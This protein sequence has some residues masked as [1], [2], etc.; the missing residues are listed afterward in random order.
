MNQSTNNNDN[1]KTQ[2]E[3]ETQNTTST[4]INQT[5]LSKL[6]QQ[7]PND[8]KDKFNEKLINA[9]F[10]ELPNKSIEEFTTWLG[11]SSE[12]LKTNKNVIK[13]DLTTMTNS[14]AKAIGNVESLNTTTTTN[15]HIV[16]RA[17][18]TSTLS[19]SNDTNTTINPDIG[20][21]I[22]KKEID[23]LLQKRLTDSIGKQ[24]PVNGKTLDLRSWLNTN[25]LPVLKNG[26]IAHTHRILETACEMSYLGNFARTVPGSSSTH[27]QYRN[28]MFVNLEPRSLEL[29]S[30]RKLISTQYSISGTPT[31][32]N[33]VSKAMSSDDAARDFYAMLLGA[34]TFVAPNVDVANQTGSILNNRPEFYYLVGFSW[35][36]ANIQLSNTTYFD[37]SYINNQLTQC[38]GHTFIPP[39]YITNAGTSN[40][41]QVYRNTYDGLSSSRVDTN[42]RIIS[43]YFANQ[44]DRDIAIQVINK[45]YSAGD[46]YTFLNSLPITGTYTFVLDDDTSAVAS[47]I[48]DTHN[49]NTRGSLLYSLIL[50]GGLADLVTDYCVM[51]N[52]ADIV[53]AIDLI[54]KLKSN[55]ISKNGNNTFATLTINRSS[56]AINQWR[57]D[58]SSMWS[59]IALLVGQAVYTYDD[60]YYLGD[61]S[62]INNKIFNYS[63]YRAGLYARNIVKT[64][65]SFRNRNNMATPRLKDQEQFSMNILRRKHDDI[66]EYIPLFVYDTS[67]P[68]TK[69]EG[70]LS[71]TANSDFIIADY[72]TMA[73]WWR[74]D[75][76]GGMDQE[77]P[78]QRLTMNTTDQDYSEADDEIFINTVTNGAATTVGSLTYRWTPN[79]MFTPGS[80]KSVSYSPNTAI[81]FK[82]P[83]ILKKKNRC[84]AVLLHGLDLITTVSPVWYAPYSYKYDMIDKGNFDQEL[85]D[86]LFE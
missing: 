68:T 57:L 21:E 30:V 5:N 82:I 50:T 73:R 69:T 84:K 85:I 35:P 55:W 14:S 46:V 37:A 13:Y 72:F 70:Y 4:F 26:S 7:L 62:L 38:R 24:S 40:T 6:Q 65:G 66:E 53:N 31:N 2:N 76:F 60:E 63:Y 77:A 49:A 86:D 15:D 25:V 17:N 67:L 8:I 19:F 54:S 52:H 44:A 20:F 16:G 45:H 58:V 59:R 64:Y 11:Q 56:P 43:Y 83:K 18:V 29:E 74:Y 48:Y 28:F 81:K 51:E 1:V 41:L 23:E 39:S 3:P 42:G 36:G 12:V 78:N 47:N 9:S 10:D 34:Q 71:G 61:E 75:Y 32:L 22:T 27:T 33:V 79:G 80:I